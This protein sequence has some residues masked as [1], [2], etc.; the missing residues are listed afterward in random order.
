MSGVRVK[1]GSGFTLIE[2]MIVVAVIGILATIAY[3]SYM[4]Y[5]RKAAR[6]EAKAILLETAQYLERFNTTNGTY[7]GAA[8]VSSVSPKLAAG[9]A[10]RYNISF[11]GAATATAYT[12]Q[13]V[14]ANAQAA[15]SCGTLT[16][17]QAGVRTA[18]TGNCW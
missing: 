5:V 17:N 14:P 11:S 1:P 12:L 4:E 18:A 9:G 6:G 2:L 8:V 10:V 16:L 15:D 13:A 7:A 3:P